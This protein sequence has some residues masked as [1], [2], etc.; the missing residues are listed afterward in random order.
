M[1]SFDYH[2]FQSVLLDF[3]FYESG[4]LDSLVRYQI[5]N[6]KQ[7]I[8]ILFNNTALHTLLNINSLQGHLEISEALILIADEKYYCKVRNRSS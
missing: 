4:V 2:F 8:H 6:N 5:L 1:H 3:D 7:Q